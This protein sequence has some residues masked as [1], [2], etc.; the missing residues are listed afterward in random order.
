MSGTWP[1][2]VI[3]MA[4]FFRDRSVPE[5]GKEGMWCAV[6]AKT[7][8]DNSFGYERFVDTFLMSDTPGAQ[9]QLLKLNGVIV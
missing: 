6:T 5:V 3:E 1:P 7:H 9:P 8:I 2:C 4:P